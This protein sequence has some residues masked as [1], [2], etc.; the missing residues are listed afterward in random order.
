MTNE[1]DAFRRILEIVSNAKESVLIVD[2]YPSDSLLWLYFEGAHTGVDMKLLTTNID[3]RTLAIARKFKKKNPRFEVR[4]SLKIHDRY[5]VVD[6]RGWL[7]GPSLKDAGKK[8]SAIV[9][10]R[11]VATLTS[12]LYDIW[13]SSPPLV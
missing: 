7:L 5:I 6:N 3:N 11:D 4:K 1:Y 2:P 13:D 10:L 8:L 12:A 9:E